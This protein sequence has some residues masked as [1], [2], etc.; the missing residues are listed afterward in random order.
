MLVISG[1]AWMRICFSSKGENYIS[2]KLFSLSTN[3]QLYYSDNK[4]SAG[5]ILWAEWKHPCFSAQFG[6]GHDILLV[7]RYDILS[8]YLITD[9]TSRLLELSVW[10]SQ[11]Y[12]ELQ[13]VLSWVVSLQSQLAIS[14][15]ACHRLGS[16]RSG[17]FL[18]REYYSVTR[19]VSKGTD[20]LRPTNFIFS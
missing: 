20:I 12:D 2:S 5:N 19:D 11:Y 3:H 14:T 9:K 4:R 16:L 18:S 17:L 13:V 15:Y 7:T 6:A 1:A 10:S 8:L